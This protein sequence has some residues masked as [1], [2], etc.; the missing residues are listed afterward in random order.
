[1]VAVFAGVPYPVTVAVV[2]EARAIFTWWQVV[3]VSS[4]IHHIHRA[5]HL[6]RGIKQFD[7]SWCIGPSDVKE[8]LSILFQRLGLELSFHF[9][10]KEAIKAMYRHAVHLD[11]VTFARSP[12]G[13]EVIALHVE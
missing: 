13:K 11:A 3:E 12:V 4:S 1:M 7:K 10:R 8:N 9:V 6:I 2:D 5:Q